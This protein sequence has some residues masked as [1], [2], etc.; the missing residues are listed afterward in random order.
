L[1]EYLKRR[2]PEIVR[3]C[4]GDWV[5]QVPYLIAEPINRSHLILMPQHSRPEDLNALKMDAFRAQNANDLRLAYQC[6]L[7]VNI[8][9]RGLDMEAIGEI[10][11]LH[12]QMAIFKTQPIV[13]PPTILSL[14]KKGDLGESELTKK[15]I[16]S[17]K[18]GFTSIQMKTQILSQ[19]GIELRNRALSLLPKDIYDSQSEL[20]DD[21]FSGDLNIRTINRILSNMPVRTRTLYKF[22][23]GLGEYLEGDFGFNETIHCTSNLDQSIQSD[24]KFQTMEQA[25]EVSES[26]LKT[27]QRIREIELKA[28]ETIASKYWEDYSE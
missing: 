24:S 7:R 21:V 5:S 14:T 19:Q 17:N 1:D 4:L 13:Q 11:K 6:W 22:F 27:R 8:A 9:S 28:L 23:L 3:D 20:W 25:M 16:A 15:P 10:A 26:L 2:V 12:P 18:A